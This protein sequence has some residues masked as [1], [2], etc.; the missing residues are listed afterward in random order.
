MNFK[1]QVLELNTITA[2][3]LHMCVCA[4][5]DREPKKFSCCQ[6]M[7]KS[8]DRYINVEVLDFSPKP[9]EFTLGMYWLQM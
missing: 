8:Q 3:R 1:Y 7:V 9:T 5:M 2:V 4:Y 6:N